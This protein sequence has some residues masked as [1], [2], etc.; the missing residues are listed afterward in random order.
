[1]HQVCAM[2]DPGAMLATTGFSHPADMAT[3]P[4]GHAPGFPHP[5]VAPTAPAAAGVPTPAVVSSA[6]SPS[7]ARAPNPTAHRAPP[8]PPP[9]SAAGA[10]SGA[11]AG[12]GAAAAAAPTLPPSAAAAPSDTV[13]AREAATPEPAPA[14]GR[15]VDIK[16]TE[17]VTVGKKTVTAYVVRVQDPTAGEGTFVV[18]AVVAVFRVGL[19]GMTSLDLLDRLC[20]APPILCLQGLVRV[21]CCAL[22]T[23]TPVCQCPN[24]SAA[25]PVWLVC[26]VWLAIACAPCVVL[27]LPASPQTQNVVQDSW[28]CLD[29]PAL[30]ERRSRFILVPLRCQ[31]DRGAARR[32]QRLT[33]VCAEGACHTQ[34]PGTLLLSDARRWVV[35]H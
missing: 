30:A 35:S 11:G 27:H 14:V 32:V 10:G 25:L 29:S 24:M 28:V 9:S 7:P 23:T 34:P 18:C 33:S 8:P 15:T 3:V 16:S 17:Q 22:L 5:F 20:C 13:P 31:R 19:T 2:L 4:K 1:M 6:P 26:L 12:A 21:L